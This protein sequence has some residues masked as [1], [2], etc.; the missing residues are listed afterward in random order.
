MSHQL[1]ES[2]DAGPANMESRYCYILFILSSIHGHLGCFHLLAYVNN[3]CYNE[4]GCADLSPR[5]CFEFFWKHTRSE[6][7]GSCGNSIV[8]IF[9]ALLS[10]APWET[11]KSHLRAFMLLRTSWFCS[12]QFYQEMAAPRRS[13][14]YSKPG[15]N[16][17]S[18]EIPSMLHMIREL[19]KIT[20]FLNAP[21]AQ[22]SET[23]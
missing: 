6:M 4:H 13:R 17:C 18:F 21:L 14:S 20:Y 15:K 8:P 23:F 19:I 12:I 2:S 22:T 10:Q 11:H 9:S 5:S 3:E 16:A 1:V 7:A